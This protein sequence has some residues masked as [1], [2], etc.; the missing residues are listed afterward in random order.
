M[1]H[2]DVQEG[3]GSLAPSYIPHTKDCHPCLIYIV[4]ATVISSQVLSSSKLAEDWL[5]QDKRD[6]DK[7]KE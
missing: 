4:S 2:S 5:N 7:I 3:G 1:I 6:W